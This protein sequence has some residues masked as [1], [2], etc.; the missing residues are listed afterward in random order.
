MG[1]MGQRVQN[2]I[3]KKN[4]YLYNISGVFAFLITPKHLRL[5][6]L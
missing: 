6:I 1:E 3:K 2:L 4:F 5:G